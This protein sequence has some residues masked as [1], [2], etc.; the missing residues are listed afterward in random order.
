ML[1]GS[2]ERNTYRKFGTLENTGE[3][4]KNKTFKM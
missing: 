1:A 4:R 2:G 3:I